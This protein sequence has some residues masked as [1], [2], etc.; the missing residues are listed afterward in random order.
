MLV[1]FSLSGGLDW[2]LKGL[3]LQTIQSIE[4]KEP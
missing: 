2:R 3:D 4:E 1:D